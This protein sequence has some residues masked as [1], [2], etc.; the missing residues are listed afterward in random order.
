MT[1]IINPGT[2]PVEHATEADARR[3]VWLLVRDLRRRGRSV[4][5][6]GTFYDE[7]DGY[8]AARPLVD[9][10]P[11]EVDMPGCHPATTR[12]GKPWVSQRLYVDGSS[13]LWPFALNILDTDDPDDEDT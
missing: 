6:D 8:W 13:W 11:R 5:W 10:I 1:V 2:G 9:G 12:R 3:A 4:E 7:W